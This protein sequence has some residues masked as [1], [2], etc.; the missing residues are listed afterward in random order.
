MDSK[1][2]ATDMT[3]TTAMYDATDDDICERGRC[4]GTREK[5]NMKERRTGVG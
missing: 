1:Y 2:G 5:R 4:G 3:A